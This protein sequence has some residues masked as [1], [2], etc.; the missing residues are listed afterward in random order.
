MPIIY[1]LCIDGLEIWETLGTR[2]ESV[3]GFGRAPEGVN[4]TIPTIPDL[5]EAE[6]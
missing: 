1:I 2:E 4:L 6:P 5:T 3:P